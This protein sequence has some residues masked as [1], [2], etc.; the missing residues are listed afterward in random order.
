M[1]R[2]DR[3]GL[4]VGLPTG[5]PGLCESSPLDLHHTT[6]YHLI[7]SPLIASHQPGRPTPGSH[8]C[9]LQ[10]PSSPLNSYHVPSMPISS[11]PIIKLFFFDEV[12]T[13]LSVADR[14][15]LELLIV[16]PISQHR[17]PT[18]TSACHPRR[19]TSPFY[20]QLSN[21]YPARISSSSHYPLILRRLFPIITSR[22]GASSVWIAVVQ[23]VLPCLSISSTH[24]IS[25]ATR[26]PFDD[27]SLLTPFLLR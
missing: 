11:F 3:S 21:T 26:I 24:P 9:L 18:S 14:P 4:G 22:L 5:V 7:T 16:V 12:N 19:P 25:H 13:C 27:L 1:F 17:T 6:P 23:N 20:H 8:Q 2:V 15:I 10:R